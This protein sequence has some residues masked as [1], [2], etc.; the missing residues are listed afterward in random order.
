M[1][2]LHHDLLSI[3]YYSYLRGDY[4]YLEEWIKNF[5]SDNVSGLLA[6]LYFMSLDEM[7]VELGTKDFNVVEM[8]EKSVSIFK[9]YLPDEKVIFSIE[10]C[11]YINDISELEELYNLG[12]RN[13]LLVWNCPNKYGSGNRG[14]YG[15]TDLGREFLIKAID[16]GIS[17]DMSHMN[18]KT[19]SD[20]IELI[21]EQKK[22][23]KDV[24]VIASHSN[25]FEICHHERNLDDEQLRELK[26]VDGLLGL[27]AYGPFVSDSED[28]DLSSRYLEHIERAIAILGIDNI[29]VSTDDMVFARELFDE[30][31]GK[32][33]FSYH[34]VKEDLEKL[35]S[36]KFTK[37][38]IERIMYRNVENKL[39]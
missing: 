10:G 33:V 29:G 4:G 2:D 19:F 24:K 38:E 23:G 34:T 14:D 37:D 3:M 31:F 39:F 21:R 30:D 25:C 22:L 9:K 26:S 35:L 13:I 27:V 16:L 6:N 11:D 12:L 7:D 28:D 18:K 36:Q 32:M 20:T 8:F 15:L 1:I 5:N 17:I